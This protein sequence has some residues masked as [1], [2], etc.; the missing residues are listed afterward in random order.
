MPRSCVGGLDCK[1]EE[2]VAY[3]AAASSQLN[4]L[5][6]HL[7]RLQELLLGEYSLL[8]EQPGQGFLLNHLGHEEFFMRIRTDSSKET[9]CFGSMGVAMEPP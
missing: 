3:L 9:I 2:S 5:I 7:H 4:L 6:Y 8:D 1:L